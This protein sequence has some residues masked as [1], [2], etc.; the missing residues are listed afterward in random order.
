M[1]NKKML[2]IWMALTV[3]ASPAQI[4]AEDFSDGVDTYVSDQMTEPED[5]VFTDAAGAE[6]LTDVDV[7]DDN[8]F[9]DESDKTVQALATDEQTG[10]EGLE[11]EYIESIDAYR[12]TKGV[13]RKEVTVPKSYNG[14]EVREI[15]ENAFKGCDKLETISLPHYYED[16]AFTIKKSA[17]EDCENLRNA[18]LMGGFTI[19]SNAFRNCPKLYVI[20]GPDNKSFIADDAFDIDSKVVV[21]V[22]EYGLG[23]REEGYPF[24]RENGDEVTHS[25][26]DGMDYW[27]YKK[28][29]GPSGN[30]GIEGKRVAD[31]D[32]SVSVAR[33][34]NSVKG[35][36]RKAFYGSDKLEEV[37]LGSE[38]YFIETKA[39]AKCTNLKKLIIPE[40]TQEIAEDAFDGCD[41]LTIY[42]PKGSYVAKFAKAH[43]IPVSY[44]PQDIT[45]EKVELKAERKDK[46]S[47]YL[48]LSWN[49]VNYADGYQIQVKDGKTGKYQTIKR[50]KDGDTCTYTINAEQYKES[51]MTCRVRAYLVGKDGKGVYTSYKSI[52][53]TLWPKQPKIVSLTKKT[54][55]KATLKWKKVKD[56]T[57]YCVYR[58]TDNKNYTRVKTIK[59]KNTVA[60]TDT[61][62]KKG[63]AYYY[64][65]RSYRTDANGNRSYSA[66]HTYS[67]YC[68]AITY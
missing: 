56:A 21:D 34:D 32:N 22:C 6:D 49:R 68:E 9:T 52:K 23:W 8:L 31:F 57:G 55:G 65:I 41:S 16:L 25:E 60:Y 18:V 10:T 19:E 26:Q 54:K 14:K 17:F 67:P 40:T 48:I 11:Y 45:Q 24:F 38:N 7:A 33:V 64:M 1:K 3:A 62:L 39:F 43:N 2:A 20:G 59:S 28:W 29:M 4:Y 30:E 35:I 36:G 66:K 51:Q 50:I 58:S 47:D 27:W 61:G 12:V 46:N 44:I 37:Q 5:F 42:T 13:N 53:V 63:T 15:G